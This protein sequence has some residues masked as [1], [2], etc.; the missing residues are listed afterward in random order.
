MGSG[1]LLSRRRVLAY[2]A[3]ASGVVFL[4]ACSSAAPASPTAAPSSGGAAAPTAG[5]APVAA[6]APAPTNTP[7]PAAAAPAPTTAAASPT[8]ATAANVTQL[9]RQQTLIMGESDAVNQFTDSQIMNPFQPAIAR[10]GWQLAFEPL[11]FYDMWWND[12]VCGPPGMANCKNG[13]IPWQATGYGYNQDNTELTIN[14]REGITWSDGQPFTANDVVFTLNMLKDN[15]PKLNFSTEM[16]TWVKDVAALDQHTVKITLTG[17]NPRFMFNYFQWHSDIGFPIVPEHIFK[18]QDATTYTNFD[19]NKGFPIGTGPFKLALSSLE[20][21][22]WDR[23]EDWWAAKSGFHP[24]PAMQRVIMLPNFTDEKQL[25]LITANQIEC[26]HGFQDPSIIQTALSRN[27]KIQVWT[28]NNQ[29]PFG[30]VDLATITSMSFNCSKPPFNDPDIRWAINYAMDRNQ[31]LQ[32][33]AHGIGQTILMPFPRFGG[34][35]QYYDAGQDLLQKYPL[36]TTDPNKT[37]QIMQSK[38]YSKDSGGFWAKDGKRWSWVISLPPPFFTDITPVIVTQLRKAGFDVSFKSP[39]NW[40]T[41]T[42]TGDVDAYLQVPAGS[43][44][45]PFETMDELNSKWSAPTGQ[46]AVR[47]YRWSNPDYDAAVNEMAKTSP[48]DPKLVTLFHTAL[49]IWYKELPVIPLL[50]RY[51]FVPVNTTY[52]TNFPNEKNPYTV[53]TSWHRTAQMFVLSLKPATG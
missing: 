51:L 50:Q 35:A 30:A 4:A 20:Q 10:S 19:M 39:A 5:N 27:P 3:G 37:A 28:A 15:A 47:T 8:P 18:G 26:A 44:R 46:P 36:G 49:E 16:H 43:V 29:P 34:L 7:A 14:L 6:N 13:E 32:A 33:G 40:G 11:Y 53:P 17:P 45:D 12:Q 9:P 2:L 21:K 24:L 42:A 23:R 31:I 1:N 38:G 41:I 52:W 25:E 22:F 48:T